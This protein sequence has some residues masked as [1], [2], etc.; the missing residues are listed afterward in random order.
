[1]VLERIRSPFVERV[2]FPARSA[3]EMQALTTSRTGLSE[4]GVR[5]VAQQ[6]SLLRR[7]MNATTWADEKTVVLVWNP[8]RVYGTW[9]EPKRAAWL[10]PC[11]VRCEWTTDRARLR[12][13]RVQY[14]TEGLDL[15]DV[16]PDPMVQW[17][18]WHDDA[19]AAGVAEPN[20]MTISTVDAD[21]APDARIVLVRGADALG[22]GPGS[23]TSAMPRGALAP[24]RTTVR[25]SHDAS[26][27]PSR[28]QSTSTSRSGSP[29]PSTL[30]KGV[31]G[32]SRLA[33]RNQPWARSGRNCVVTVWPR[34]HPCGS[35][36][37]NCSS[38]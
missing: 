35:S 12:D 7:T 32:R 13:R 19:F 9:W 31:R 30:R 38:T 18:R 33:S 23:V 25:S 11:N 36:P 29:S 16:D 3:R 20:A 21:G 17:H 15:D 1:M 27:S 28:A 14:E 6:A 8:A 34:C 24:H 10:A 4:R 26:R 5:L 22:S 37:R 2:N